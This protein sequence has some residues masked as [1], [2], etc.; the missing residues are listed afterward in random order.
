M[1]AIGHQIYQRRLDRGMTQAQLAQRVGIPQ[2]NL[3]NIEKGR[4]DVTVSTLRR[5]A[6][7]LR[8]EMVDFFRLDSDPSRK[9]FSLTRARLEQ[10]ARAIATGK[11]GGLSLKEQEIVGLFRELIPEI[12]KRSVS[13]KRIN[14]SWLKLKGELGSSAMKQIANR[15]RDVWGRQE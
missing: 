11:K 12:Q 8:V 14:Q 10:M 13:A 2:P 3:S 1:L 7:G 6:C 4:Q 9:V 15:V 5:I